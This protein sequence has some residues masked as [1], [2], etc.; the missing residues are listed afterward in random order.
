MPNAGLVI[1][2]EFAYVLSRLVLTGIFGLDTGN[3]KLKWIGE[4]MYLSLSPLRCARSIH[5]TQT[6]SVFGLGL[7]V[8][9]AEQTVAD[10]RIDH[11]TELNLIIVGLGL[12]L[13]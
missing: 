13:P 1:I 8:L 5:C 11:T 9:E 3:G 2:E 4:G 10:S 7:K 12:Q 6:E